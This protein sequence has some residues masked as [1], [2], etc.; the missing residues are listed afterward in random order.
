MPARIL[1][2]VAARM[3][4]THKRLVHKL[5]GYTKVPHAGLTKAQAHGAL[6]KFVDEL[7]TSE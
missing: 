7:M 6:W 1:E 3:C 4:A 5:G 2:R